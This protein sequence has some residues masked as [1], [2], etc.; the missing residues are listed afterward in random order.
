LGIWSPEKK[1]VHL[2]TTKPPYPPEFRRE[3]VRLLRS[4]DKTIPRIAAD[5]GISDQSLRNWVRQANTST[6]AVGPMG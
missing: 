3:A 6:R 5:L 1:G 2:P 4:S